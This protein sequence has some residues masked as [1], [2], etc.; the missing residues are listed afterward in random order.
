MIDI[1]MLDRDE[2]YRLAIRLVRILRIDLGANG[3]RDRATVETHGFLD[4]AI[5]GLRKARTR[6]PFNQEG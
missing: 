2:Q 6:D 1:E 5:D 4:N 3:E